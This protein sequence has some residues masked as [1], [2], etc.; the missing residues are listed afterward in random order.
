MLPQTPPL[1]LAA[2]G[3][4]CRPADVVVQPGRPLQQH[5]LLV[6]LIWIPSHRSHSHFHRSQ[7]P[8]PSLSPSPS[9]SPSF[10]SSC[11]FP[12]TFRRITF[13][14]FTSKRITSRRLTTSIQLRLHPPFSS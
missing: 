10:S 4:S 13:K 6:L 1:E 12:Y 14:R 3:I 9:P 8:H 5:S 2:R 11:S 7:T